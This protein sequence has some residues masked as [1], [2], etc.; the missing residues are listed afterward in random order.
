MEAVMSK[1]DQLLDKLE[2]VRRAGP[3]KWLACCPA[4][5]DKNPSLSIRLADDDRI[6]IH[7]FSGCSA[8]EI[9]S[10]VGLG[11]EDLM[12]ENPQGYDRTR[13]RVP[14]FSKSELFDRLLHESTVLRLAIRQLLTGKGLSDSDLQSVIKAENLI[15]ELEREVRL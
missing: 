4:H 6:L 8:H 5:A 7:C 1:I 3:N 12:P 2:K 14:R 15:D 10:S 13:A 9:V 11:L